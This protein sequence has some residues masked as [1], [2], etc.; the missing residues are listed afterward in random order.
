[1]A[2]YVVVVEFEVDPA[3]WERFKPLMIENARAS[4]RDEPGCS[5]FDVCAP[6]DGTTKVVLYEI[7]DDERAFQAH[8]A[9]PHYKSFAEAT[10]PMIVSRRITLCNRL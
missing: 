5:Q 7:Y 1:M 4:V 6:T 8:L 9:T 3:A 2:G 10:K